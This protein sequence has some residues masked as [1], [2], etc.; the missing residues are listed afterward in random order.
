MR[1][2]SIS[3]GNNKKPIIFQNNKNKLIGGLIGVLVLA[4]TLWIKSCFKEKEDS[5]T[6]SQE[7]NSSIKN[8]SNN[9]SNS[10]EGT[11]NINNNKVEQNDNE[12]HISNEFISGNKNTITNKYDLE[13][14]V[15]KPE[16]DIDYTKGYPVVI[17]TAKP[18]SLQ[19]YLTIKS[20]TEAAAYNIRNSLTLIRVDNGI[21]EVLKTINDNSFSPTDKIYKGNETALSYHMNTEYQ[22]DSTYIYAKISFTNNENKAQEPF[23]PIFLLTPN[24]IGKFLTTV[25][26]EQYN[27]VTKFIKQKSMW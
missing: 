20:K 15:E 16:L 13:N 9:Y 8:N 25:N 22:S 4:L 3:S 17:R 12:G 18:D 23:R 5:T 6:I 11:Q 7:A 1:N 26:L 24:K 19:F 21:M 27:M 10:S 14:K 2:S